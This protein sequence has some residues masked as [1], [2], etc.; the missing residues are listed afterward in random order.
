M[1][2]SPE[3]SE[4]TA[5]GRTACN[6]CVDAQRARTGRGA[7]RDYVGQLPGAPDGGRVGPL[8]GQVPHRQGPTS[9]KWASSS[10]QTDDPSPPH[11]GGEHSPGKRACWQD[12][13]LLQ[14]VLCKPPRSVQ[15]RTSCAHRWASG[16]CAASGKLQTSRLHHQPC[17]TG[18]GALRSAPEARGRSF[19]PWSR[20]S[21][22][23]RAART[24]WCRSPP[25]SKQSS[26]PA[27]PAAPGTRADRQAELVGDVVER[28]VAVEARRDC[29]EECR[30]IRV[31]LRHR[32]HV[33]PDGAV[34]LVVGA[35][36]LVLD[37]K[38]LAAEHHP[39]ERKPVQ[40]LDGKRDVRLDHLVTHA[41][42]L[43]VRLVVCSLFGRE[44]FRRHV[45]AAIVHEAAVAVLLAAQHLDHEPRMAGNVFDRAHR[46]RFAAVDLDAG[47]IQIFLPQ[48]PSL[49]RA[50]RA[51]GTFPSGRRATRCTAGHQ[52][53]GGH[54][55]CTRSSRARPLYSAEPLRRRRSPAALRQRSIRAVARDGPPSC[56]P[57]A[58]SARPSS[59]ADTSSRT[60][61]GCLSPTALSPCTRPRRVASP[62]RTWA[63]RRSV[64]ANPPDRASG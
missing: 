18:S 11:H 58:D 27:P 54:G 62:P 57:S 5:K 39:D 55:T 42:V 53:A 37:G 60:F 7:S 47:G 43:A 52:S 36:D 59:T 50:T 64:E 49:Q 63:A 44:R 4:R 19:A 20:E 26:P 14:R 56:S 40:P 33:N 23:I 45:R 22:G 9:R 6:A 41:A 51:S 2:A 35:G 3:G 61:A 46:H 25:Q 24:S 48:R 12:I 30:V 21:V 28:Q 16:R 34:L 38:A 10:Q 15:V 31:G 29:C 13:H 8:T 32:I 1:I 17:Q